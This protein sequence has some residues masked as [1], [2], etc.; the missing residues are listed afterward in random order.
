LLTSCELPEW[1]VRGIER[2]ALVKAYQNSHDDG[3][4]VVIYTDR[5]DLNTDGFFDE[6]GN[7]CYQTEHPEY[8][9]LPQVLKI[10]DDEKL[11]DTCI[12]SRGLDLNDTTMYQRLAN[13]GKTIITHKR[14][15]DFGTDENGNRFKD[16][17]WTEIS[18]MCDN[19]RTEAYTRI[20]SGNCR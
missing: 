3:R 14:G 5:Y 9:W 6:E 11:I 18:N 8:Y 13:D 7:G 10:Y 12:T 15:K 20:K 2:P 19:Y 1:E 17:S 16:L 4:K